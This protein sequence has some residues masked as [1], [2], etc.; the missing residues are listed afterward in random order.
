MDM[1]E[2]LH[3]EAAEI[4]RRKKYVDDVVCGGANTPHTVDIEEGIAKIS[5]KGSFEF[6]SAVRSSDNVKP[7]KILRVN[8][9]PQSSC[10]SSV[11]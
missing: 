7:Q 3:P 4:I 8:W 11:I 5:S 1:F 9:M 6:K 10:L 2:Y